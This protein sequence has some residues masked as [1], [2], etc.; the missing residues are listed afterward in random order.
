MNRIVI[1]AVIGGL[2]TAICGAPGSAR[3]QAEP[4]DPADPVIAAAQKWTDAEVTAAVRKYV[5][6]TPDSLADRELEVLESVRQRTLP[7]LLNILSDPQLRDRLKKPATEPAN[8]FGPA[9]SSNPFRRACRL[10]GDS[11][12][13]DFIPVLTAFLEV[14]SRE[15]RM[16]A[17]SALG[18]IGS[19]ETVAGL[20]K[21][22]ADHEYVQSNALFGL[23][24]ASAAK[25]LDPKVLAEF[26]EDIKRIFEENGSDSAAELILAA[27]GK[28]AFDVLFSP[29]IMSLDHPGLLNALIVWSGNK[30]PMPRTISA[31]LAEKSEHRDDLPGIYPISLL[32]LARNRDPQDRPRIERYM[33][34]TDLDSAQSFYAR[35]AVLAWHG[36]EGYEDRL[37]RLQKEN[38]TD[39]LSP[40]QRNYLIVK[41]FN[42]A[43]SYGF[44]GFFELNKYSS[45][46]TSAGLELFGL[47]RQADL[48]KEARKKFGD[49]PLAANYRMRVEQIRNVLRTDPRAFRDLDAKYKLLESK[50]EDKLFDYVI[51]H[52]E[53]FR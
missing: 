12:T 44:E 26:L 43:M 48:L 33:S 9:T 16:D 6:E 38:K 45:E 51:K 19:P 14:E 23:A 11:A 3:A 13:R 35:Q 10:L 41:S 22:M 2:F 7:V 30:M 24:K 34:R 36:A 25:R 18:C 29:K 52:P 42:S 21:A 5:L 32:L 37:E 28:R 49:T 47:R 53:G 50:I 46:E 15:V 20:R 17:A 1:V 4:A 8:P 27:E 40:A 39:S 31:S